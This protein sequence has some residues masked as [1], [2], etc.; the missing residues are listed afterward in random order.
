MT[1]SPI[2]DVDPTTARQL[3]AGGARLIDVRSADEH[4]RSHIRGAINVPL[5]E[6][7]QA[8]MPDG[9]LVFH[10]RSGMRTKAHAPALAA[11]A[12]GAAYVLKGGIDGWTKAGLPVEIDRGKPIEIMRQVQ[13][14]AGGLVLTG[15][16]L[17]LLV[18][19]GFFGLS[20]F[21]GAGLTFAGAT[22]WCGMAKLLAM[23]PWNRA[24]AD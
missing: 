17:G 3:L 5:E 11:A 8:V 2:S 10:C 14:V 7:G 20:A 9:P 15:I 22:G 24:A 4:A 23:M 12:G 21:V 18:S 6:L 19:P 1:I 13:M 16:V